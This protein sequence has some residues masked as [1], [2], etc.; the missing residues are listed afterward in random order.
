M[1]RI[2][3]YLN[4]NMSLK[5]NING[6][7]DIMGSDEYNKDLSKK[8]AKAVADYLMKLGLHESRVSWQGHGGKIPIASNASIRGRQEN[9]RVEFVVVKP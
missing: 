4:S 8:R 7:T 1:R 6:H 2:Y 5:I 9:R 3:G